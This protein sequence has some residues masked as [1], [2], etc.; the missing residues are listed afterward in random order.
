MQIRCSSHGNILWLGHGRCASC[1]RGFRDLLKTL[2]GSELC[3]CGT[4][5]R[6]FGKR[7]MERLFEAAKRPDARYE[8]S[9]R[10]VCAKCFE[11]VQREAS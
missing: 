4:R 8:F 10:Q 7:W 2:A 6:P 1:D 3:P 9:A 5:L 11:S